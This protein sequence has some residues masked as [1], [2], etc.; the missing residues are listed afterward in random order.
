MSE[1][2]LLDQPRWTAPPLWRSEWRN[3]LSIYLRRD[4]L[5]LPD[6]LALMQRA[7][8]L[9]SAQDQPVTSEQVLRLAHSSRCSA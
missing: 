2:L 8:V 6:A 7:E 9:L 3:V 4:L 5:Q 1:A